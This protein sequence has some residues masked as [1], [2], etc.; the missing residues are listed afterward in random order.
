[1]LEYVETTSK[2]LPTKAQKKGILA[3]YDGNMTVF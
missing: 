1:M 3:R 2:Y